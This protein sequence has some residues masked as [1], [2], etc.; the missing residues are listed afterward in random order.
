MVA[1]GIDDDD[2]VVNVTVLISINDAVRALRMILVSIIT[3]V[4]F[5]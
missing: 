3:A 4:V 1:V 5:C 2:V